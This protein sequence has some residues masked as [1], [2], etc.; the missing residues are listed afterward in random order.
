[1]HWFVYLFFC[2]KNALN[3]FL[4]KGKFNVTLLACLFPNKE[5]DCCVRLE[6]KNSISSKIDEKGCRENTN[7]DESAKHKHETIKTVITN[8]HRIFSILPKLI[9]ISK[10]LLM[11][12][13]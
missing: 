8:Q 6:N 4:L 11:I 3:I 12:I 13:A 10:T 9:N 5:L 1:M 2:P 7:R